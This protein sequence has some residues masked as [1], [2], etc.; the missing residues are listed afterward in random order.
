MADPR[1]FDNRGPFSLREVCA[2]IGATVPDGIDGTRAIADVAS[3]SGAVASHLSFYIGEKAAPAFA[4][5]A[6]GVVLVS[7]KGLP[8]LSAPEGCVVIGV[9]SVQHAF[10]AVAEMFYPDCHRIAGP[11]NAGIHPTA[12]IGVGVELGAGV[13]IGPDVE[14]GDR[15]HIGPHVVIGRGVA[16][17]RDSEIVGNTVISH[18]Y[19]GDGVAILPGA[20]IGQ[21]GFGFASSAAGHVKIPQLGRVIIQDR[22]EIGACVT[23]DRGALGDTVIGEGTKID[24][25]V[26]IGHNT[27]IGRHA[28]IVSQVGISGSCEIG[29]FV[30]L[31]G[32][33]GV[34]DHAKIGAGARL[35]GKC[36]VFMGQELEPGRDYGGIPAK[37]VREW[38]RE[39][40]AVNALVKKPKRGNS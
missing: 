3:L 31:A 27:H 10:A 23:I 19:I 37:P 25:L 5:T 28:V 21:P 38:L 7:E 20:Q 9:P 30:V 26:Q 22:V 18:A 8:K 34:S 32:Q 12:K 17:G 36:G 13:V 39:L 2:K 33:A 14:I 35:G 40:A 1:F 11:F 16:I 29:D 15:T 24:N 6:A 4:Q